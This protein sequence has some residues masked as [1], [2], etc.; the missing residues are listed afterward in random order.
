[1]S[2]EIII[3]T[4]KNV[5]KD[6]KI[7]YKFL[8]NE[9]G[10]S[11]SGLKKMLTAKDISL[12]RLTQ[13]T[14]TLGIQLTDLI[15]LAYDEEI[16]N[17]TLSNKQENALLSDFLL[18]R[19]LWRM[20]IENRNKEETIHLE[21]ITHKKLTSCLLKLENLDLIRINKAGK[22]ISTHKGLYRWNK[23]SNFVNEL[24][25]KWSQSTLNDALKDDQ[26]NL[27]QLSY[28]QLSQKSKKKLFSRLN[29]VVDEFAR[30]SRREKI[31][32]P[33]SKIESIRLLIAASNKS[34]LD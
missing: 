25:T 2:H 15:N 23:N 9:I 26:N 4:L 11:E 24:N 12:N 34:F 27:H 14:D 21:G 30:I 31:K 16:N 3:E 22:V 18:F 1:M 10:M 20:S 19:V 33:I 29:E 8:A 32:Y 13:I 7:N 5:L 6:K 17:V 28:I